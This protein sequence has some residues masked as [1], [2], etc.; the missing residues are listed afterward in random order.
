MSAKRTG[1]WC[2]VGT[3]EGGP[4]PPAGGLDGLRWEQEGEGPARNSAGS[5]E[6]RFGDGDRRVGAGDGD[7]ERVQE[8][9]WGERWGGRRDTE[10]RANTALGG[11][12]PGGRRGE[13]SGAP[14]PRTTERT[15]PLASLG[16]AGRSAG[17][18]VCGAGA[19]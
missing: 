6:G 18:G 10:S 13:R 16:R 12:L 14:S 8:G 5:R 9:L 11:P 19:G 1:P 17:P 3:G 2:A 4:E 7:R 15:R